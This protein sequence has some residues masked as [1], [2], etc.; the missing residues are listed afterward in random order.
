MSTLKLPSKLAKEPLIDVIFELRFTSH[1]TGVSAL[2][3]GLLF[4]RLTGMGNI[5]PLPISQ[6]P[7]QIRDMDPNLQFSP[8][9][10]IVWGRYAILIGDRSVGIGCLMPYPGWSEFKA[11]IETVIGVVHS[12][13]LI[14]T[15]DR[16]SVKYVD[17]FETGDDSARA[18]SQF[19]IALRL[20]KH[21][22]RAE[23]TVIR[24]EIPRA[25]FLHAVQVMTTVNIQNS[26]N[27]IR[28]GAILDVDTLTTTPSFDVASFVAELPTLL[29]D[30]HLANKHM[31]FECLSENGLNSL[32]PQYE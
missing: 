15:I 13:A 27:G 19:N 28:T 8:L 12:A 7:Q 23:N 6:L 22:V 18:L 21:A 1:Q 30:I 32:E 20:G 29:D 11:A 5:E 26:S 14:K 25:P 9:S 3:P 2:L 24:V 31:F 4:T 17:F 16:Y 10:R